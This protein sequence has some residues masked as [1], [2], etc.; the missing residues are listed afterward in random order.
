M[1]V[2]GYHPGKIL[3]LKTLVGEFFEHF[4]FSASKESKYQAN[5]SAQR[6]VKRGISNKRS[7]VQQK[8]PM[9]MGIESTSVAPVHRC[10]YC[11]VM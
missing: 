5:F 2:R 11:T 1:E 8:N 10:N 7:S 3:E 9:Q 6:Q 4:S